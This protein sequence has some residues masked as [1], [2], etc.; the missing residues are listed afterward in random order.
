MLIAEI[1]TAFAI[2]GL[3][4]YGA[5]RAT[6]AADRAEDA[7]RRL[8]LSRGRLVALETALEALDSKH[9]KLAGRVYADEYWS[10]QDEAQPQLDPRPTFT[11]EEVCEKWR[12]AQRDGPTSPAAQCM[13][14]YCDAKREERRQLRAQHVPKTARGQGELAKLNAG[15]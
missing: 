11:S 15:K 4:A 6:S 1:L 3:C 7:A 9:R 14:A 2:L 10:G 8:S 13:C 12:A 5:W